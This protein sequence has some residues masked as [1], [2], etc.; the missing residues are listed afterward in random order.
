MSESVFK[1]TIEKDPPG[2][3]NGSASPYA[4]IT[5]INRERR[6]LEVP[7][8]IEG[9]PVKKIAP[10]AFERQAELRGIVLPRCLESVGAFA[11][12]D[13]RKLEEVSLHD[14]I[15]DFHNGVFRQD[16]RLRRIFL[17]VHSGNYTVMRDI[18]SESDAKLEFCLKLPDGKARLLFPG[19]DYSFAE[20][21]M[22]RTIQFS[23]LGS[24]MV[25]R[26][27]VRRKGIGWWEYDR[28][29]SRVV[30]DDPHAAAG[31]AVCRLLTPYSLAQV[32]A[33]A[34]EEYLRGH[35]SEVLVQF[36]REAHAAGADTDAWTG[37]DRYAALR[38]MADRGLIPG[39][40]AAQALGLASELRM[41]EAC[42][43][44][45][46]AREK[47][48]KRS[49][50]GSEREREEDAGDRGR[51]SVLPE[52]HGK[53]DLPPSPGN[54]PLSFDGESGA[55]LPASPGSALILDDW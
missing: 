24:G 46:G 26:D 49:A 37:E 14:G 16:I 32:H 42:G 25:Y 38:F 2:A 22:A 55:E 35:A 33:A 17:T 1:Y 53:E 27:C 51:F 3:V 31:I 54:R 11:L 30:H 13:C 45:L 18:L 19:Y 43:I 52:N 34:Y 28:L 6:F 41:T 15:R 36:V 20:N 23:I 9:A 12:H 47:T 44:L 5:G 40:E 50:Q 8:T 10:H 4:V 7:E 39:S 21:T 29:F 48:L